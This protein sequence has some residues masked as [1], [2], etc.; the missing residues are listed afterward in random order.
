[1]SIAN[2]SE[3]LLLRI[4]MALIGPIEW[5]PGALAVVAVDSDAGS[6]LLVSLS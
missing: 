6:E 2:R 3:S 5:P 1:M 4:V